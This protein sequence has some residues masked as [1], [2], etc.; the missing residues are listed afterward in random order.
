MAVTRPAPRT[1]PAVLPTARP[2][3][4]GGGSGSGSGSGSGAVVPGPRRAVAHRY[5]ALPPPLEVAL[6]ALRLEALLGDPR[7]AANPYGLPALT[8]PRTTTSTITGSITGSAGGVGGAGEDRAGLLAAAGLGRI[9]A[10]DQLVRALRPVLRRDVALGHACAAA[11]GPCPVPAALLGPAALLAATGTVLRQAA[12]I[13]AGRCHGEPALRQWRPVLATVFADLLACE[14]LTSVALRRPAGPVS[15]ALLSAVAG[16]VVP[17]V[18]AD[19]LAQLDLVLTE[20]GHGPAGLEGRMLAK[21]AG[22]LPAAGVDAAAAGSWQTHL[23]RALPALAGSPG[24]Q[25]TALP[26]LFRLADPGTDPGTGTGTGTAPAPAPAPG[27]ASASAP[28]S[29]PASGTASDSAADPA[30]GTGPPS[31]LRFR[32]RFRRHRSRPRRGP[33]ARAAR[34]GAGRVRGERGRGWCGAVGAVACRRPSGRR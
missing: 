10:A 28:A 23:V 27:T 1:V 25:H 30:S 12:R 22:D 13:V 6:A 3:G 21:L 2:T 7:D 34:A 26:A 16:Y 32:P 15:G 9:R 33:A 29:A 24:P 20:C 5:A 31:R 11:A 8:T 4:P 18:V 14:S 17:T 19:V